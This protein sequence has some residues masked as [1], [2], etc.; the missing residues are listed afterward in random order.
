MNT[1]YHFPNG[2]AH[3]FFH[4][5]EFSSFFIQDGN[6]PR[7]DAF[8]QCWRE[9][10]ETLKKRGER[11]RSSHRRGVQHNWRVIFKPANRRAAGQ[12]RHR[13]AAQY[14][15]PG[16]GLRDGVEVGSCATWRLRSLPGGAA[17]L[18]PHDDTRA[19]H[20]VPGAAPPLSANPK[21]RVVPTTSQGYCRRLPCSQPQS[22]SR[23]S[24]ETLSSSKPR[25]ALWAL[26]RVVSK[27]ALIQGDLCLAKL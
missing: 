21:A 23:S 25:S 14:L 1:Q 8:Q 26:G 18:A 15:I 20:R 12:Y 4:S 17:V 19:P 9:K 10:V 24:R 27:L 13:A 3:G 2:A 11:H 5:I 6:R 7:A 22:G 16:G